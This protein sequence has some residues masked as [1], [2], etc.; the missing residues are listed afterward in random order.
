MAAEDLIVPGLGV[1]AGLAQSI[2]EGGKAKK[3][4]R[5]LDSLFKKRSAYKTPK[6][7]FDILNLTTSN[8][9]QGYSDESLNYLTGQ[10]GAGLSA[11]LGAAT[12]LGADPNQLSGLLD[13]Y[14]QDIF[15]IGNENEL[16]KMK[17]FDSLTNAINLVSQHKD[18]EWQSQENLIKDQMQSVAARVGNAQKGVNSGLNLALQGLSSIG[19]AGLYDT[20][21]PNR[22]NVI[23]S[24]VPATV[25]LGRAIDL[26]IGD[27]R[28][29]FSTQG[30]R[31]I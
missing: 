3:A 14:Y 30:G 31:L 27:E 23:A 16:L 22:S 20:P 29:M 11:G 24:N 19:S 5:E 26:T 4:N 25:P 18:A 10:A 1:V 6:E 2:I 9:A 15:K 17:K 21:R 8:A 13:G 12:R 28:G 7:V